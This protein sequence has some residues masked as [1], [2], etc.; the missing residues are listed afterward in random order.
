MR[1]GMNGLYYVPEINTLLAADAAELPYPM[2]RMVDGY[3]S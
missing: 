3:G 2:A 1:G